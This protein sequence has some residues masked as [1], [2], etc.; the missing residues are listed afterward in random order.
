MASLV[1]KYDQETALVK[2]PKDVLA[3]KIYSTGELEPL[4]TWSMDKLSQYYTMMRKGPPGR[5]FTF[6]AAG[7]MSRMTLWTM[8]TYGKNPIVT[9]D[10]YCDQHKQS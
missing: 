10:D 8:A 9:I 3:Y 1:G 7:D 6:E 5:R 4:G 2:F